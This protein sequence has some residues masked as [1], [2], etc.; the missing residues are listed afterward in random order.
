MSK[1][2]ILKKGN[3]PRVLKYIL[4]ADTFD[5]EDYKLL[6]Q[7]STTKYHEYL[8]PLIKYKFSLEPSIGLL[9]DAEYIWK[10]RIADNIKFDISLL[11]Y[12]LDNPDEYTDD[13]LNSIIVKS[14]D[15]IIIDNGILQRLFDMQYYVTL[16]AILTKYKTSLDETMVKNFLSNRSIKSFYHASWQCSFTTNEALYEY[17]KLNKYICNK[18]LI[19]NLHLLKTDED[20]DKFIKV[21]QENNIDPGYDLFKEALLK[22][23]KLLI[24]IFFSVGRIYLNEKYV[25]KLINSNKNLWKYINLDKLHYSSYFHLS[26]AKYSSIHLYY[27]KLLEDI[28]RSACNAGNNYKHYYKF[29]LSEPLIVADIL[30]DRVKV[31]K[32]KLEPIRKLLKDGRAVA[33][34]KE[35]ESFIDKFNEILDRY[36]GKP[37]DTKK[38]VSDLP[39][40]DN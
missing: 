11:D 38:V 3:S 22:K 18:T 28:Y 20:A 39:V 35:M 34:T 24:K 23:N 32:S 15:G 31:D 1:E 33:R 27:D 5:M 26:F 29:D 25:I 9:K 19:E 7:N 12:Y 2:H 13:T 14:Q 16:D 21:F 6:V 37:D 40:I 4:E 36:V 30:L 8:I 10:Y 17:L